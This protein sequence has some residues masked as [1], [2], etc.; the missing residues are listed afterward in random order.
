MILPR[1]A[2]GSH[3]DDQGR[4]I[5][6]E[7]EKKNFEFAGKTLAEVWSQ[8]VIDDYAVVAE[9]VEPKQSEMDPKTLMP[10]DQEWFSKH[11]RTSQYCTQIVKCTDELCCSPPRSSYFSVI[12]DRF[13]PPPIPLLQSMEGLRAPE[14]MG[15]TVFGQEQQN[16]PSLFIARSMDWNN[17]LP[18]ST[19]SFK[20]HPYD[21]YCPSVQSVLMDRICKTCSLYFASKAMLKEHAAI[22]K[23]A[24]QPLARPVRPVRVA[25]RRQREL[26]AIIAIEENGPEDAEWIDEED[27]DLSDMHIPSEKD[28]DLNL[29][30]AMPV[31]SI[32]GHLASEW[33]EDI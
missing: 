30:D 13:L 18:R 14:R 21:L 1:D 25:A 6:V 2:Y 29:Q 32:A 28:E 31:V 33:T 10:I 22:H 9:F 11:V 7:L 19:R 15:S 4:T 3:L 5:D 27:L 12:P 20:Q 26:M 8:L 24:Q 16:F 17:L 23:G